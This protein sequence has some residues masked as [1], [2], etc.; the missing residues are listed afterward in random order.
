MVSDIYNK[1]LAVDA[2]HISNVFQYIS[3]ITIETDEVPLILLL[4]EVHISVYVSDK[5]LG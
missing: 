2:V 3:V 4:A 1:T 5:M